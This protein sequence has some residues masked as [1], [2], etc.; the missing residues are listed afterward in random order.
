MANRRKLI[1]PSQVVAAAEK[2]EKE[3]IRFRSF[4]KTRAD[5]EVLDLQF[6]E[7][8]KMIFPLYNCKRCRNCCKLFAAQIPVGDI[9]RDAALL[10]MSREEFIDKYLE[11]ADFG[12][13]VGKHLPCGFLSEAGDCVLGECRPESCKKFPYTDQPDRLDSLY[14]VLNAASVCPAAYEILEALKELYGFDAYRR[15]L[16]KKRHQQKVGFPLEG[17]S[18]LPIFTDKSYEE[19]IEETDLEELPF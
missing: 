13:W 9:D 17:D 7:L 14:S 12:E 15:N 16:R 6:K 8:H 4:L 19:D 1:Q 5:P 11:Q 18:F 10:H 3:N 2:K